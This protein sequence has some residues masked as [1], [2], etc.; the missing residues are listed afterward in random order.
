[1]KLHLVQR[2]NDPGPPPKRIFRARSEFWVKS[3][4]RATQDTIKSKIHFYKNGKS[5]K[6]KIFMKNG[7]EPMNPTQNSMQISSP[8][9]ESMETG[10]R[11]KKKLVFLKN[12]FIYFLAGC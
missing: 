1:M 11:S 12:R 6:I 4:I 5:E 2:K 7:F 3:M 8:G 10:P 9:S